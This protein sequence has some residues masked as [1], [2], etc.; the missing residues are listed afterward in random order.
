MAINDNFDPNKSTQKNNIDLEKARQG[1]KIFRDF[2]ADKAGTIEIS[3]KGIL[4]AQKDL[5][6]LEKKIKEVDSLKEKSSGKDKEFLEEYS[7]QL[8]EI[9]DKNKTAVEKLIP[10]VEEKYKISLADEK[11]LLEEEEKRKKIEEEISEELERIA[12]LK[13][14]IKAD[15]E[16]S[17]RQKYEEISE[18]ENR[19]KALGEI[20]RKNK[21]ENSEEYNAIISALGGKNSILGN[22]FSKNFSENDLRKAFEESFKTTGDSIVN[23]IFPELDVAT[24]VMKTISGTVKLISNGISALRS[25]MTSSINSAASALENYYGKINANLESFDGNRAYDK[26]SKDVE[27][28][29]GLSKLVRQTDYLSKI[30]SLSDQ[31]L[32]ADIEQRALLETIKDRTLTSFNITNA[33]LTRLVRLGEENINI[34]QFGTQLQ[35]KRLLNSKLFNDSSYLSNMFDSVTSAILEAGVSTKSDITN[36]NSTVQ[37]WLGAMYASG[38]SDNVVSAIASGIN[39]LGSGNVNAL[40]QDESTQRLFLLAMDRVNMDYADI[41]QQGL[42]SEDT[43][44]LLKSVVDLLSEIAGN[45]KDNLVLKSS[46][47]NLFNLNVSDMQAIQNVQKH[48]GDIT[49]NIVSSESATALTVD[50]VANKVNQ[51]TLASEKFDNVLSNFSYTFGSNIAENSGLYTA[52]RIA[53]VSYNMLDKFSGVGG[54]VGSV[55]NKLKLVPAAVQLGIG[56]TSFVKSLSDLPTLTHNETLLQLLGTNT[57]SKAP[58]I[59]DVL[60][61]IAEG[62]RD[63]A[64]ITSQLKTTFTTEATTAYESAQTWDENDSEDDVLSILEDF[65]GA[66]MRLKGEENENRYAFAVSLQGMSNEV[67]RSFASIFADEDAMESTFD[68]SNTVLEKAMFDFFED[69]TSNTTGGDNGSSGS[70]AGSSSGGRSPGGSGSPGSRSSSSVGTFTGGQSGSGTGSYVGT[71]SAKK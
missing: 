42:S 59:S 61:K 8:Q 18:L 47:S 27:S 64:S 17:N 35:L 45:T 25:D 62:A 46:Y 3:I 63:N 22:L 9:H 57:P 55:I 13:R 32:I 4:K 31:G 71:F 38:L 53:D 5:E 19:E 70:G 24:E 52:Y 33:G 21:G 50:A 23:K 37:T 43:S 60:T 54:A 69:T 68:G 2:E 12:V 15:E 11:T 51:Y 1:S 10:V 36:F 65:H 48:I 26:I 28:A 39:A 30:A 16:K 14:N 44:N 66:L 40:A 41:L 49:S 6:S 56:V 34:N 20:S 67:L 58:S 7:K 29:L